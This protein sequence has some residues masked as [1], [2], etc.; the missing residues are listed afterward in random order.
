MHACRSYALSTLQQ[1]QQALHACRPAACRLSPAV[2]AV[3][4]SPD[5]RTSKLG[6]QA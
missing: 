5:T 4:T 3:Q 2:T 1:L 6:D